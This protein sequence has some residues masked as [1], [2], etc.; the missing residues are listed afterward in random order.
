MNKFIDYLCYILLGAIL[1]QAIGQPYGISPEVIS[2]TVILL[3]YCFE[4]DSIYSN[5][6]RI[7]GIEKNL[8]IWKILWLLLSFKFKALGEAFKDLKNLSI[9]EKNIKET[10]D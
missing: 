7:H 2:V 3:C 9:E 1:G 10:K 6:R 8:S 4:L 5:V